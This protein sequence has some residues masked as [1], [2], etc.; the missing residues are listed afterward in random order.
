MRIN[1]RKATFLFIQ[2][3]ANGTD[4]ASVP[5]FLKGRIMNPVDWLT[6]ALEHPMTELERRAA[7]SGILRIAGIDEAGRGPLA[8]PVVAG[9]V[10]LSTPINE[11]NDSKKLTARQREQLF[12]SIT[13]GSHSVGISVIE[14]DQVDVLGIQ[15]ANYAAMSQAAQALDCEPELVLI[16]GFSVPGCPFPQKKVIKGDQRSMSI[17]AAS[18]VAKVTRDQLMK[19]WD[20]RYPEY[21]F[22]RHKGYGTKAHMNALEKYGPCPIH[23]RSFAPLSKQLESGQLL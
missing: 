11:A 7:A 5:F 3:Y 10:I 13:D 9:A 19:E 22:A 16:D 12:A 15:S 23:R 8:G 2:C 6:T 21:G 20:S 1:R 14:A 4:I 18:I 17:A